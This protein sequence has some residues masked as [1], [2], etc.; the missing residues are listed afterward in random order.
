M[1]LHQIYKQVVDLSLSEGKDF[2]AI[3]DSIGSLMEGTGRQQLAAVM[4]DLAPSSGHWSINRLE[5][6]LGVISLEELQTEF[7]RRMASLLAASLSGLLSTAGQAP[8]AAITPT[9]IAIWKAWYDYLHTGVMPWNFANKHPSNALWEQD[10]L[11]AMEQDGTRDKVKDLVKDAV[12]SPGPLKR[13]LQVFSSSFIS[14]LIAAFQLLS[15]VQRQILE[16]FRVLLLITG[17]E[18]VYQARL[19]ELLLGAAGKAPAE[20]LFYTITGELLHR[21]PQTEWKQ[22]LPLWD[23]QLLAEGKENILPTDM[24][25]LIAV[26]DLI[27]LQQRGGYTGWRLSA[28]IS[29]REIQLPYAALTLLQQLVRPPLGSGKDSA[30]AQTARLTVDD[31][32]VKTNQPVEEIFIQNA[33]LVLIAA[34]LPA[35][36]TELGYIK[37]G[38]FADLPARHKAVLLTAFIA[39]GEPRNPDWQLCLPK[40]LC[41]LPPTAVISSYLDLKEEEMQEADNMLNA[42]ISHWTILGDTSIAGLRE[43]FLLREGRLSRKDN[44]HLLVQAS[45]IDILLETIPWS[46]GITGH[47]WM[48][49]LLVTEWPGA[50]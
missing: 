16:A 46:F 18:A 40:I 24:R 35:L 33:G 12:G 22:L 47:S 30:A 49:E 39:N 6:D 41:G 45:A 17:K 50:I 15:G 3:A 25:A 42:V 5:I 4:D 32:A 31:I 2:H 37:E 34:Y 14:K 13:L 19:L 36:F 38:E 26:L 48:P 21:F 43:G 8:A 11:V 27:S 20:I 1:N 10:L 23:K 9:S 29:S 28:A 7:P 44:W